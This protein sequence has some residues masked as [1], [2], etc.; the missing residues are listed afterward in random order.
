LNCGIGSKDKKKDVLYNLKIVKKKF[1]LD[2]KEIFLNYQIHSN[3]IVFIGKKFKQIKKRLRA[4]AIITNQSK[5]PIA[6]LTADCVPILLYDCKKNIIAAIHAG[7]RGALSGIIDNVISFIIKKGGKRKN[8]I[9]AIG[10]SISKNSYNIGK[11]LQEK[12]MRQSKKNKIFFNKKNN[13]IYFNLP[14]YVKYQLNLN[15]IVNIDTIN[16]DTFDK[17]NNFFSA[18]RSLISKHDDYGRNISII[19]IN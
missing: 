10:P 19:M 11:D 12:F 7:W 2:S 1:G 13:V 17:K 5:L 18:R 9:A 14:G 8:I 15:K 4:D 6:V 16:I 3:K